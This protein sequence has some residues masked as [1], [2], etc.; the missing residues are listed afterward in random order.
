MIYDSLIAA[1]LVPDTLIRFFIRRRVARKLGE[2]ARAENPEARKL[3]LFDKLKRSPLAVHTQEA[4]EQHYELP[5]EFFKAVL[6]KYLKYSCG[7]WP[8][9]GKDL[10]PSEA[11]M[12]DLYLKRALI[13]P[14]QNILELGCGW[15]SLSLY[16]AERF[17]SCKILA[18]SNSRPQKVFIEER[19][20]ERKLKN[21]EIVT[22]DINRLQLGERFDRVISIE[23]FEHMR[24][25][26][27][28]L[29]R[30][31]SWL[32]PEGLLF[33]HIFCHKKYAYLFDHKGKE[34]WMGRYFFTG[35][36]MPSADLFDFFQDDLRVQEKW[37]IDGRHY[38]KTANAWLA[39]MDQ[40]RALVEPILRKTYGKDAKKWHAY[41]RI[42][43]MACAELFG[44]C[45]GQE[46]GVGHYLMRKK[47][48]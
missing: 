16:L 5:P 26:K 11:K 23:M 12:L 15:G 25:Y 4:N 47:M 22:Q 37:L 14:G 34:D 30:I 45:Q 41:W 10:D 44:Y 9:D 46:W 3:E 19:I 28:L 18:V 27:D 38:E 7:L 8:Q 48:P 6:G 13:E 29:A 39:K 2:E 35:G 21:L 20:R 1:G 36:I 24:N 17:P 31:A 40:N 32:K 42:F 33:I 43:F